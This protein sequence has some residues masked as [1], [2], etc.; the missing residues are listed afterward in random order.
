[1]LKLLEIIL[2]SDTLVPNAYSDADKASWLNAINQVFFSVVKIPKVANVNINSGESSI[3]L[4]DGVRAKNID[5]VQV[6]L[7]QYRSMMGE[8]VKPTN[9][10]WIFDDETKQLTIHPA[11]FKND[12]C[13]VRYHQIATTTFTS[14]NLNAVPDAPPEYHWIYTIGLCARIAKA[15]D[16]LAK[17]N[18][19]ETDFRAA[20]NVAAAN[21]VKDVR[22]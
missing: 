17:A 21:Y 9:N 10:Y 15:Q 12:V 18:N 3:T 6:G 19:Y 16:D 8:D 11:P 7:T 13:I 22:Q 20:L 2:E 4:H 14:S 1:M 5:L